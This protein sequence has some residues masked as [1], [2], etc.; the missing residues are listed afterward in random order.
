MLVLVNDCAHGAWLTSFRG[1][2]GTGIARVK[3]RVKT[4]RGSAGVAFLST[5]S[6]GDLGRP[7]AALKFARYPG[8]TSSGCTYREGDVGEKRE[9]RRQVS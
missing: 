7:I 9:K 4:G 5:E 6:D 1:I 2:F 3:C 8:A